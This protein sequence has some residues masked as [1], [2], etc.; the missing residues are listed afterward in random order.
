MPTVWAKLLRLSAFLRDK[1]GECNNV[2]IIM[3]LSVDEICA[4]TEF[5][6]AIK[7]LLHGYRQWH[8]T[9]NATIEQETLARFAPIIFRRFL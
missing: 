1:T 3:G 7:T 6:K 2:Y 9:V 4:C 8:S 5:H